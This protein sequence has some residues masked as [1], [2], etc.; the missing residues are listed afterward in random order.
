MQK[1]IH[2]VA[3]VL[4]LVMA[5]VLV[6]VMAARW[7]CQIILCAMAM[8]VGR[9]ASSANRRSE[10]ITK[11]SPTHTIKLELNLNP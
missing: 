3:M 1:K 6:L 8:H 2:A 5:M 7:R 10:A 9:N 11:Y 4:V